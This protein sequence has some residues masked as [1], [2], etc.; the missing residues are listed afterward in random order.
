MP[1]GTLVLLYH[2]VAALDQDPYNF[3]VRP[4]H[5]EQHCDVLRQRYDVVPLRD[6]NGTSRQVVITFDDGYVDNGREARAI[7][8]AAGL[9][10]TFFITAG[11]LGRSTEIWWDRLEQMVARCAAVGGH[12]DVQIRGR[13]LWADVR[14]A[15]ARRRAHLALYWRLRPLPPS[16][17]ESILAYLES[18]LDVQVV[19][20][21][22]HRWMNEDEL[23]T[24]AATPGIDIG[25]HTLTHP[26]LTSLPPERQREE[27]HGSRQRLQDVIGKPVHLF[28]YPYG[29]DG[30][31]D[32][33]TIR[34]VRDSGY[35]RACTAAGGL[36]LPDE[37]PYLIP[38]NVAGDWAASTFE[39]SLN[40]WFDG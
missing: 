5:F 36:A 24:L 40:R 11:Q 14:S 4:E 39:Q 12:I 2:R 29:V 30:A 32:A 18:R 6:A 21:G 38:R 27:I 8:A 19:D 33:A 17:I 31:F 22:T 7:L 34:M 23:C 3:A 10:A 1:G 16:E 26:F 9:P 13:R 25:A 37:T 28:S 15:M 20:R 35:A